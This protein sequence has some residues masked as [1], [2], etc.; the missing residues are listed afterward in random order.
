MSD[1]CTPPVDQILGGQMT[2]LAANGDELRATYTG[3]V[4]PFE[5]VPGAIITVDID[6]VITGGTGRFEGATGEADMKAFV[7]FEGFPDPDWAAMWIW[8]GTI[9]Y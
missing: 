1:H 9:S 7:I 5:L 2:F 3:T 4:L 6:L 8:E